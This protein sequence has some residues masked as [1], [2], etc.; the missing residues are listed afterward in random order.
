MIAGRSQTIGA[1]MA[2]ERERL[3]DRTVPTATIFDESEEWW[4]TTA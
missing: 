3:A 1:A 2:I 4:A